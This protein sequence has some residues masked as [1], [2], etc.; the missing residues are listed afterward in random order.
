MTNNVNTISGDRNLIKGS[1]RA[2]AMSLVVFDSMR[3]TLYTMIDPEESCKTNLVPRIKGH[4]DVHY[5]TRSFYLVTSLHTHLKGTMTCCEN[6]HFNETIF[7]SLGGEELVPEERSEIIWNALTLTH[8]DPC[9]NQ[10]EL[11]A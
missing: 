3:M 8:L 4:M 6:Y 10:C 7:S 1:R 9:T 2:Y 11:K 5:K